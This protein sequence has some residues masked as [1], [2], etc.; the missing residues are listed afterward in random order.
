[1]FFIPMCYFRSPN[2]ERLA[3]ANEC[4]PEILDSADNPFTVSV[5][6]ACVIYNTT[7]VMSWSQ[8]AAHVVNFLRA[9]KR[10][11]L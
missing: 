9:D 4:L 11:I 6:S 3:Y 10:L 5:S 2:E 7:E 1:M 8:S